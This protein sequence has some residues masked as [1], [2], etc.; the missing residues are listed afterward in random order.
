MEYKPFTF[1]VAASGEHFT[2]REK[3]TERL[4]S[5][6][7]HGINTIL[8]SPRRFG[9]TSLVQK[10]RKLAESDALR[11]VYLDI[12][13]CRS[14]RDFY[15]AFASAVLKQT[16]SRWEEWLENAKLFLSRISPKISLDPDPAS[17]F[18]ISLE[19]NP[20]SEDATEILQLPEKIADRKGCRIVV[21]IDEF[22]QIGE[23][24]DSKSFQKQ[25]RSVWQLQKSVSYCL[26]G[27]K[28][29]LMNE[30][31]EKKSLPFYKFG[32]SI[33]LGKIST[34][35]WIKYICSRFEAT[36]KRISREMAERICTAVDN[37]SS[38][39]QQLSWLLWIHTDREAT[40]EGFQE[41]V[42]D[43]L[44]QNTPLFEKQTEELTTYQMNFLRALTEGVHAEFTT[45]ETLQK[46][47]LGT[48]ANVSIIK[49]SLLKQE[50]I[51][52]ER[53]QVCIAD[54]VLELW[55]KRELGRR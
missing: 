49:R 48:S 26:F 37:H 22:Q 45:Q 30:L 13:A 33:Y 9:K 20:K 52:T 43:L 47:Q 21:C 14:D 5:N 38:Y 32:D 1:G 10:V 44:A 50:L 2:D 55:L 54:P 15:D 51:E 53:R 24:K 16:S 35:D 17:E 29:H 25:L 4:L 28:K 36:G 19:L 34:P 39:V 18:S 41:A 7:R 8:I 27:S 12:F 46:Y 40:E 6:F 3:E 42:Q 31:F 11:I 23:F